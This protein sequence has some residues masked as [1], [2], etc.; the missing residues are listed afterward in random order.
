MIYY[1]LSIL[2]I[3][4]FSS[5]SFAAEGEVSGIDYSRCVIK[6]GAQPFPYQM[7]GS[8]KMHR[9][10]KDPNL[11]SYSNTNGVEKAVVKIP[12]YFGSP[13]GINIFSLRS[14]DGK[15]I[16]SEFLSETDGQAY[17]PESKSWKAQKMSYG[18]SMSLSYDGQKCYVSEFIKKQQDPKSKK[19][20][21][22]V[23]YN[24]EM[25]DKVL[26]AEKAIGEH[27]VHECGQLL[28]TIDRIRGAYQKSY[29]GQGKKLGYDYLVDF[30]SRLAEYAQNNST[31][32]SN[33]SSIDAINVIASCKSYRA[34]YS[35][36][37]IRS[38]EKDPVPG[39]FN[40]GGGLTGQ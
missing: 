1:F 16:S 21:D 18:S 37:G 6:F 24:K 33:V 2:L 5:L 27:K 10:L 25:C 4:G 15:V 13:K 23:V 35:T 9:P 31:A 28:G 36:D 7:G 3:S 19:W 39:A 8:G 22:I 34:A 30:T 40:F 20:E 14:K 11:V 29:A 17:D 26:A 32:M 12:P 38:T